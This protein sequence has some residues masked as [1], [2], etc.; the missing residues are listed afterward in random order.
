M[1]SGVQDQN[2]NEIEVVY[3]VYDGY[4]YPSQVNYGRNATAG[5]NS[6]IFHAVLG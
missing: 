3:T 2:G 1:L 6:H 5:F 4:S